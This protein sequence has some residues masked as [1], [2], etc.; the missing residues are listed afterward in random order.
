MIKYFTSSICKRLNTCPG[1]PNIATNT[2]FITAV[3]KTL[4]HHGC[5]TILAFLI[6]VKHC[7]VRKKLVTLKRKGLTFLNILNGANK[8]QMVPYFQFTTFLPFI[9]F[10]TLV[11]I[12]SPLSFIATADRFLFLVIKLSITNIVTH[13]TIIDFVIK[14][15]HIANAMHSCLPWITG[16]SLTICFLPICSWSCIATN[17]SFYYWVNLL[18]CSIIARFGVVL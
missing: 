13:A 18:H 15:W 1:N 8:Y 16:C 7:H 10:C 4:L 12:R 3:C 2:G 14:V 5:N 6:V 11:P 17:Q 9:C